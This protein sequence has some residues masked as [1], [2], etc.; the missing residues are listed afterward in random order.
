MPHPDDIEPFSSDAPQ[1]IPDDDA[2]VA[3]ALKHYTEKL[4]AAEQVDEIDFSNRTHRRGRR[5]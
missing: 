1:P 4:Q 2:E 3:A 5:P